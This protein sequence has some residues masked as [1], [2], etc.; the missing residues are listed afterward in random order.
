M[1]LSAAAWCQT[2]PNGA[3]QGMV[4][5]PTGAVV[6]N[7]T[8][9]ARQEETGAV[10]TTV[11][12]DN[13]QF[14]FT[15]LPIGNYTLHLTKEGFAPVAVKP[16]LVSVGEVATHRITLQL[17]GVAGTV[18]VVEKADA[19]ESTA[20]TSSAALGS[21][22]IEE[23]PA[24]NRNYLSFVSLAPGLAPSSLSGTQRSMAGIRNPMADSGF[25]F[26]GMR[27]RNNAINI[28]G[29]DNRDETTGGN[30]V[31]IGLEMVQEFR[32]AGVAN[33][34]EFG[35]AA[36]G[37]VN[38]VTRTGD[39]L[40]HGDATFFFQNEALN[41]RKPEVEGSVKPRMRRY[42]PGTSLSGPIRRDRTFFSAAIEYEQESEQ[43]WSETPEAAAEVINRMLLLPEF[44]GAPVRRVLHGLFDAG[45]RSTDVFAKLN[46]QVG[47]TDTLTARY[48]YSRGRVL[49]DVQGVENFQDRS[50]SGSSLTTDHSLVGSWL[51]VISPTTVSELRF[52]VA[53]RDQQV[54]PNSYGSL[55][56]IPGVVSFGQGFRLDSVRTEKHYELVESFNFSLG[57][58]RMSA[59]ASVHAVRLEARF[60]NRFG[61]IY[62]FPTLADFEAGR[63]DVFLQ[64][65]GDPATHLNTT[66]VGVWFQDRWEPKPGLTLEA[67]LRYDHQALPEGLAPAAN[68]LAPRL[69]LAWKPSVSKPLVLR[70]GVGLFYDRYPLAFLNDAIQKNGVQGFEQYAA[71]EDA[72]R[73]FTLNAGGSLPLPLA[74]YPHSAYRTSSWFPST[75]SRKLAFGLER[76][77]GKDTT[78]S[79]EASDVRGLHLPRIRNPLG[80]LPPN[81]LLEQ[82]GLSAFRGASVTLNRRY[83]KETTYLVTYNVGQAKDDASD[84]DEQ[85]SDPLNIRR[86]WSRS[87]QYQLHRLAASGIFEFPDELLSER[88]KKALGGIT[89][90][91]SFTVATGRPINALLTTDAYRTGAYPLTA[92]PPGLGRNP[93]F[94]PATVSLDLR[95]MK[96][97]LLLH[98]RTRLQFGVEGFNVLNHSNAVKVSEFFASAGAPLN[99][100]GKTIESGASRQVQLFIQYEF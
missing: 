20:T 81:Y 17:A 86:D 70:A 19:V 33:G 8:V 2:A 4:L 44:R 27:G 13:G 26:G 42:Q 61:G 34:A 18:S 95:L 9:K 83:S 75:Y 39:N 50:A 92:R 66:P 1:A 80:A 64:A 89:L 58:H 15:S 29:V 54:R 45:Q 49:D 57:R 72:I 11:T 52:Q 43:E 90:S 36:G 40:W 94:S 12:D 23:A 91:P 73:V 32:V 78:F 55:L 79:V 56:E 69:G 37:M 35:G 100:Y 88:L 46:H 22:R 24:R 59:G 87:R 68:N 62:I 97:I 10:R 76:G 38:L 53:Q 98:E 16:F 41:A 84:F 60:R 77:V 48:A 71:G 31:V 99:S 51:R 74:G 7:V 82:T 47:Q 6:V 85:P 93:Y 14:Y 65:F 96:T 3:I 25:S 67:G 28:D 63:P 5:D 30:R 21:S